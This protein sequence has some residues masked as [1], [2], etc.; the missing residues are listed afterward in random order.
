M[1]PDDLRNLHFCLDRL[2]PLDAI[3]CSQLGTI[4]G[5]EEVVRKHQVV[6]DPTQSSE[7][8]DWRD[9]FA[10][11]LTKL[12]ALRMNAL[13]LTARCQN[14]LQLVDGAMKLEN[15]RNVMGL[16]EIAVDDS[17]TIR[18]MTTITLIFLSFATLAVGE[19]LSHELDVP[20]ATKLIRLM[21]RL[22]WRCRS[23][24]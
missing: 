21:T 8:Q 4:E 15:Q 18:V 13:S 2:N 6:D 12:N 10:N 23:S 16:T 20:Q 22:L 14:T 9:F 17:A 1:S 5:L 19:S 3:L 7:S 24:I 11:S